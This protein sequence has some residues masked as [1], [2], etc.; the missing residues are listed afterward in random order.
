MV[1]WCG[2]RKKG[3]GRTE[4]E[5]VRG[6]LAAAADASHGAVAA[7]SRNFC[8]SGMGERERVTTRVLAGRGIAAC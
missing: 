3:N 4:A 1:W 2:Q 7:R 8:G 5:V 6:L